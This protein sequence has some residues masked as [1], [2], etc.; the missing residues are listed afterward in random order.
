MSVAILKANVEKKKLNY[1]FL[2]AMLIQ[3]QF[4]QSIQ[5][6]QMFLYKQLGKLMQLR[7]KLKQI[8]K[9]TSEEEGGES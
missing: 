2:P 3:H 1:R 7:G 9:I 5:M 8:D 4:Y 6:Q